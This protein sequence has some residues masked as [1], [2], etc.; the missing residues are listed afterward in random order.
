MKYVGNVM[1]QHIY[2]AADAND[3]NYVY[4]I[5]PQDMP[6]ETSYALSWKRLR[7]IRRN[8]FPDAPPVKSKPQKR[9]ARKVTAGLGER[10]F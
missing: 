8:L 9:A 4:W 3:Q 1:G 10:R 5:S 6:Y 2:S 7:E